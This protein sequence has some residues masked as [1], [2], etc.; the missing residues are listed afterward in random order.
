[1]KVISVHLLNYG[2]SAVK[3]VNKSTTDGANGFNKVSY[4]CEWNGRINMD[5]MSWMDSA[6][7]SS[8]RSGLDQPLK[9]QALCV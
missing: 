1:M 8:L 4:I 3:V 2:V 7:F 9:D 5:F 6:V